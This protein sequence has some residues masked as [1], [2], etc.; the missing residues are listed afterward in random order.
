MRSW[1]W[2]VAALV[3]S[4]CMPGA[5]SFESGVLQYPVKSVQGADFHAHE[6]GGRPFLV[7]QI[8]WEEKIDGAHS[9]TFEPFDHPGISSLQMV[10]DFMQ[11]PANKKKIKALQ[12]RAMNLHRKRTNDASVAAAEV[13]TSSCT[14]WV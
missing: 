6:E 13:T 12:G 11:L 4:L 8:E 1:W 14:V 7:L 9:V 3:L 5:R 10:Q 2:S